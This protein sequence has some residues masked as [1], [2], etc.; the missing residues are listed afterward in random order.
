[1]EQEK[2]DTVVTRCALCGKKE[3]VEP[4]H[5]DYDKIRLN[6]KTVYICNYCSN[7]LR[8]DADEANKPKK[9]M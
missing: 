8:F 7:K 9:P 6:P 4:V 2:K 1:M 5:K 3:E